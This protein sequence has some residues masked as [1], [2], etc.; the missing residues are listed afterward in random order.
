LVA[1]GEP[2]VATKNGAMGWW[3]EHWP[4]QQIRK[5]AANEPLI[6]TIWVL[7]PHSH[8]INH[9]IKYPFWRLSSIQICKYSSLL[10]IFK[11]SLLHIVKLKWNWDYLENKKASV[12]DA[13]VDKDSTKLTTLEEL[14]SFLEKEVVG[15]QHHHPVVVY[16]TPCI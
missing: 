9:V 2:V 15:I 14:I 11:F 3:I 13:R 7:S 4:V 5:V 1:Q 8:L 12:E 10:R 6:C 16:Q